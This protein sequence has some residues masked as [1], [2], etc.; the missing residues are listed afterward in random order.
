MYNQKGTG[1]VLDQ[2]DEGLSD[3]GLRF[4]TSATLLTPASQSPTG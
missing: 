3:Y 2:R 1:R 4:T